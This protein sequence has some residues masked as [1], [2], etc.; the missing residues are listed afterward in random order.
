MGTALADRY[1]LGA[2]E[3]AFFAYFATPPPGFR[4]QIAEVAGAGLASGDSPSE[5][6]RAARLLQAYELLFWDSLTQPERWTS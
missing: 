3:L 1:G 4:E 2:D 5:A 6:R